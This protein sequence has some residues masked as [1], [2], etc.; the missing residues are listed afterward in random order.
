MNFQRIK[1]YQ[2]NCFEA[3]LKCKYIQEWDVVIYFDLREIRHWLPCSSTQRFYIK[4]FQFWAGNKDM[5][6][7][8]FMSLN[9][10][11]QF[12]YGRLS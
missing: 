2:W 9:S 11:R 3:I 4:N 1:S 12:E 10:C 7:L 5:H 6:F 8:N